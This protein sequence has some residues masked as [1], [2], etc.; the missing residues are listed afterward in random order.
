MSRGE[1]DLVVAVPAFLDLTAVGLEGLP[2]LGEESVR[3]VDF[4]ARHDLGGIMGPTTRTAREHGGPAMGETG[5]GRQQERGTEDGG[6]GARVGGDGTDDDD[7][8]AVADP[9][10]ATSAT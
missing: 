1:M 5:R 2:A 7:H 4:R 3:L 6:E 9:G 10:C 8:G